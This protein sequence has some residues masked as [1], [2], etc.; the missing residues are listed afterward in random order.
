M[1]D[2]Y[3][4]QILNEINKFR[5]APNCIHN[6]CEKIIKNL[7]KDKSKESILK[8]INI[9][10]KNLHL[11]KQLPILQYNCTLSEIARKELQI[12]KQVNQNQKFIKTEEIKSLM[13]KCFIDIQPVMIL[14]KIDKLANI[15]ESILLENLINFKEGKSIL[16]DPNFTQIGIAYDY[17]KG[18][19]IIVLIFSSNTVIDTLKIRNNI[20]KS[21]KYNAII[22]NTLKLNKIN[23]I[24]YTKLNNENAS[25]VLI[26]NKNKNNY[27]KFNSNMKIGQKRFNEIFALKKDLKKRIEN[28][29]SQE[30]WIHIKFM[31]LSKN[32]NKYKEIHFSSINKN[33]SII[34]EKN[35]SFKYEN[36]KFPYKNEI[37]ENLN[38]ISEG[39]TQNFLIVIKRHHE[40]FYNISLD[41][42][43]GKVFSLEIIFYMGNSL[44]NNKFIEINN[45]I[46]FTKEVFQNTRRY[47]LVNVNLNESIKLYNKY[48]NNKIILDKI[49][50]NE[51]FNYKNLLYNF[52]YDKNE[53][54]GKIF[55]MKEEKEIEDF[56]NKEK[57]LLNQI[58]KL[59]KH[60][61]NTREF[62]NEF[63]DIKKEN[64]Y[65]A[66]NEKFKKIPYI[67]KYYNTEPN[68]KDIEEIKSLCYLNILIDK[69]KCEWTTL[70]KYLDE[71]TNSIFKKYTYLTNKDKILIILNYLIALKHFRDHGDFIFK[72]FYDLNE[73][74]SYIQ[75]ELFYRNIISNLDNNS[76]L[77]FLYLQ[78]N[79][80]ADIDFIT[81][82]YFYKTKHISLI[83][84]QYHLLY[85]Y[86]HPYF[87]LYKGKREIMAWNSNRTQI[88]N[89]NINIF[90][91][92]R[93]LETKF[94]INDT[95][96]LLLLKMNE[97]GYI[98]F[99]GDNEPK[100]SHRLLL[101]ENF[102]PIDNPRILNEKIILD[103]T[104]INDL[105]EESDRA[106]ELYIFGEEKIINNIF[107]SKDIDLS[108]LYDI[109]LYIERDFSKLK[110]IINNLKLKHC[111]D[112]N[113]EFN[114][115][116]L[117]KG[118]INT[119]KLKIE[120]KH[121]NK[122][123]YYYDLGIDSIDL[124]G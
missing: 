48:A 117:G 106:I 124:E 18:K 11:I 39:K 23:P 109:N 34:K 95:V 10:V 112:N 104:E 16:C 80:G 75:S 94:F 42:E 21:N 70:I 79:S 38:L 17:Y 122:I 32:L 45:N 49:E 43:D 59:I 12:R 47:N 101:N 98:K 58:N 22:P 40:N 53:K 52:I 78:L 5:L 30:T 116:Q 46:I 6:N 44:Y 100:I 31:T 84:I 105:I 35:I 114:I 26:K 29:L 15:V 89:Y 118:K 111:I 24:I 115:L 74:S 19:N 4:N 90:D 2:K 66:I 68:D 87:F 56:N 61:L 55:K 113:K 72:S 108:K 92:L 76:S 54:L 63:K 83:E 8:E 93:Y 77:F 102:E 13:P 57:H 60:N 51:I 120:N 3:A 37:T 20:Q 123:Y 107:L 119:P 67:L 88:K 73:N 1:K 99:K 86:F 82:N 64:C 85:E 28:Y 33:I 41:V 62:E 81:Q 7:S 91:N 110:E 14:I 27:N 65:N 97:N 50:Y 96:K 121:K 103:G 69:P 25:K 9:W 71:D 36:N